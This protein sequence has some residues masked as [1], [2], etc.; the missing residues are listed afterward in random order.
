MICS[1]LKTQG[2]FE[3]GD[4]GLRVQPITPEIATGLHLARD[5]GL[6]VSDVMPGST[7][8][9]AGIRAQ[10]ILLRFDGDPIEDAAQYATSFYPKRVGQSVE[11]ELLRGFRSLK[12]EV[13]I[14]ASRED[15]EDPLD[16]VDMQKSVIKQLGIVAVTLSETSRHPQPALRSKVGILV[17]GKVA[18]ADVQTG[19]GVGDLIRSVNGTGVQTVEALRSLLDK[20]KPGDPIV[21]QIERHK[22]FRY[23]AFESD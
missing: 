11:L 21:L 20:Q 4:I 12:T 18:G 19:L 3:V 5:S 16:Q 9:A 17:A 15:A 7:A 6:I 1:E 13:T 23:L 10:D 14:Q 22:K 8:E 2:R